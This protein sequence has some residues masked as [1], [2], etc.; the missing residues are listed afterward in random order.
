M[1][2]AMD[3]AEVR[4][5]LEDAA[6][7]PGGLERL[8]AGDTPSASLV[9]GHLAGCPDCAE[10]LERLRRSVGLIAPAI[11]MV[12][13]P[14]LRERT[15]AYVAAVGRPRGAA[16]AATAAE[17]A[18]EPDAEEAPA[19]AP[20]AIPLAPVPAAPAPVSLAARRSMRLAPLL[21][22]AAAL[23]LAVAGGALVANSSRNAELH[24]Q[25]AE[26][27]ALGDVARGTIRLD[28][29][30]DVHHVALT[31]AAAPAGAGPVGQLI[32]SPTSA[33]VVVVADGLPPAASGHEYRCWLEQDGRRTPIGKMFFGGSIAY[34]VGPVPA[35]TSLSGPTTFGVSLVELGGADTHG[36]Q[37]LAGQS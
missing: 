29:Q 13:P 25:A 35:L 3:H 33:E 5:I 18:A 16:V 11:R 9:A 20:R 7:E 21:G 28:A 30:P 22:L 23:V 10:E 4:E 27:E 19:P 1:M 14:E 15:L 37:V 34:W 36:Q 12:P 6:I 8:M 2:G 31:T 32:Y 24:L 26:I 17:P